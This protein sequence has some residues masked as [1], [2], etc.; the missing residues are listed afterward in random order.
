MPT[1]NRK[2]LAKADLDTAG[3]AAGGLLQPQQAD[4]FFRV[5]IKSAVLMQQ[6]NVT[7]MRGPKER[8]DKTRFGSRV[9][10]PGV[11]AQAL[12]VGD[13]SKPD[14]SFIELDAKLVKAEVRMSDEVLE[15]QIERGAYQQTIIETLAQA[16]ARDV[17]FLISQGDTASADPLLAVLDG[18]I[19]QATSNVVVAGGVKLSKEVLRDMLK[20][21]PDEFVSDRLWYTTNRQALADYNDS[22]ADRQTVLGDGKITQ[23]QGQVGDYQGYPVAQVPEYPNALGGGTNETVVLLTE[24]ENMMMGV[25]RDIRVRMGEDI[26]AGQVIIVVSM[27]LDVQYMHEPAVVKSTGVFGV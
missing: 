16:V 26:S 9:L 19:K 20:T 8:R 21:M 6:I 27:R 24:R 14:L 2:L 15:D 10:K 13:R 25:H 1:D 12:A 23:R 11:E 18:F 5:M 22:L 3:L 4:R 17:D 7:P